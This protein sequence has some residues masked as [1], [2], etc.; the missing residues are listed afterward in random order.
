MISSERAFSSAAGYL[1][2]AHSGTGETFLFRNMRGT[3]HILGIDHGGGMD[4]WIC[5]ELRE[6]IC[7]LDV[8][9]TRALPFFCGY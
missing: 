6:C 8:L 2:C 5:V 1:S 3:F 7:L 9:Q 4:L